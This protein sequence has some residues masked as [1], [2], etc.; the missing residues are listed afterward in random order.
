ME[1]D[2]DPNAYMARGLHRIVFQHPTREDQVIKVQRQ[3]GTNPHLRFPRRRA[4]RLTSFSEEIYEY[5]VL[6]SRDPNREPIVAPFQGLVETNL[7]LG[8]M[9]TRIALPGG[10][11]APTLDQMITK[12]MLTP[13]LVQSIDWL[14]RRLISLDVVVSDFAPKNLVLR[15]DGQGFC[16]VDGLGGYDPFTKWR[17]IPRS[18]SRWLRR[19]SLEHQLKRIHKRIDGEIAA[20]KN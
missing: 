19:F 6:R 11:I 2:L 13:E 1:V 12:K 7:G 5:L 17:L 15:P 4:G 3:R 16:L 10:G 20:H 9:F 18:G 14:A 8:F